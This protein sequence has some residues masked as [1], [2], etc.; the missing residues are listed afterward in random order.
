[1]AKKNIDENQVDDLELT[2]KSSAKKYEVKLDL[3][4]VMEIE[5]DSK[6]EAIEFYNN[7]M[8]VLSTPNKHTVKKL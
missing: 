5:A 7:W 1:M 3:C 2:T 6:Y 4:P 8:G